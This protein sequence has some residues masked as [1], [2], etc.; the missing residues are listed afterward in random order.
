MRLKNSRAS[1]WMCV[2]ANAYFKICN[3]LLSI[4][5]FDEAC[6]LINDAS[7]KKEELAILLMHFTDAEQGLEKEIKDISWARSL[8]PLQRTFLNIRDIHLPLVKKMIA[9]LDLQ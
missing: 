5:R 9:K 8:P 1:H 4:N 7:M 3:F 2:K 6:K